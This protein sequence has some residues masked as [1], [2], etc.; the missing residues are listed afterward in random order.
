MIGIGLIGCGHWGP[1]I[2]RSFQETGR[3]QV[4]MIC[5]AS[6]QRRKAV[7][8]RFPDAAI[9]DDALEVFEN[10]AID[11]VAIATPTATHYRLAEAALKAGKHV[12][13][14]KPIT[15]QPE[16][17]EALGRLAD[18]VGRVLMVGHVFLYNS[19][20]LALR[21][22]VTRGE[23]GEIRHM[24]FVRTNLG[25]IRTDVNALWDLAPHD[26][27]IMALLMGG[28]PQTVTAYGQSYLNSGIED[29]IFATF[30]YPNGVL[31]NV[32]SSWLSPKKVRQ[33]TVVGSERMAVWD[34][35]DMKEP[36]RIFDKRVDMPETW[37]TDNAFLAFKTMVVDGGSTVPHVPINE[38]LKAECEH[39]LDCVE[40]GARPRSDARNGTDVVRCLE[41]ATRSMRERGVLTPV[42]PAQVPVPA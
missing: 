32:Q 11:A 42:A 33:I 4:R 30:E 31:A 1:N 37:G 26:I 14:E 28:M 27:S 23:L 9:S 6:P 5:E 3:A 18:Q 8:E 29:V 12:L 19:T 24:S 2:A 22:I 34:D 41:A 39:F 21:D 16:D 7:A 40:T 10:P 35:L 20:V 13:V 17:G 15:L 25:P 38:P 36:I